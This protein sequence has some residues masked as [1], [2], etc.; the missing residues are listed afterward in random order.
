[1]SSREGNGF[2]FVAHRSTLVAHLLGG[3]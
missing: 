3:H 2:L 1:L